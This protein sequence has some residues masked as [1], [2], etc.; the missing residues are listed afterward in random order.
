MY[1]FVS[2]CIIDQVGG[3]GKLLV[4]EILNLANQMPFTNGLQAKFMQLNNDWIIVNIL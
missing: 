4:A 3:I 1:V 2:T